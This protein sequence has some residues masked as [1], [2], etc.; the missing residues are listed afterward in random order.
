[1]SNATGDGGRGKKRTLAVRKE[2]KAGIVMP[3]S[4][5]DKRLRARRTGLRLAGDVPVFTAASE[6]ELIKDILIGA[7]EARMRRK[8]PG[9]AAAASGSSAKRVVV[10]SV[11]VARALDGD[12]E[13]DK[14]LKG[15]IV[16]GAGVPEHKRLPK[17]EKKTTKKKKTIAA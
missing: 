4:R 11:D 13:F 1:M 9:A 16:A 10:Q 8:K 17:P 15:V 12:A 7:V 14:F 5:I 2:T 6:E 3:P